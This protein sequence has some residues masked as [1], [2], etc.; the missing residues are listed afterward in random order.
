MMKS[1][2]ASAC[3]ALATIAA[4]PMATAA[5]ITYGSIGITPGS[6]ID[7]HYKVA[8]DICAAEAGIP[9]RGTDRTDDFYY[10]TALRACLYR[11]GFSAEGE[12]AYPVPL[13]GSPS[14]HHRYR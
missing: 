4:P 11:L 14:S 5:T 9:P 12:Y 7:R 13:F 6:D 1:A 2:I 10:R 8:R 3:F